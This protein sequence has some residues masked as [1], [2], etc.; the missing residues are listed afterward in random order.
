MSTRYQCDVCGEIIDPRT[1]VRRQEIRL[2]RGPVDP[3]R[4]AQR[5]ERVGDVFAEV[6]FRRVSY[7]GENSN[8]REDADLCP[9]C[10]GRIIDTKASEQ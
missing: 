10:A 6:R 9:K 1:E 7:L 5:G 2:S 8:S 4:S 3:H